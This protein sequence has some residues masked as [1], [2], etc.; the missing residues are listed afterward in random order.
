MPRHSLRS[1][2]QKHFTGRREERQFLSSLSFL[3]TF[4]TTR[5]VTHAIRDDIGPFHNVTPRGLH[6]HHLVWGIFGLLG[7]GYAWLNQVGTGL[8]QSSVRTS[9]FTSL[10][11]GAGAALTLDEFALWLHLEDD[12][13]SKEGRDSIDAVVVFISLLSVGFWGRWFFRDV[14]RE[15]FRLDGHEPE[16]ESTSHDSPADARE[17]PL[18]SDSTA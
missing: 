10:A 6:I 11:Y 5:T 8:E 15:L 16:D 12:Y 18:G 3:V 9:R 14:A 7:V 13:W 4:A 1:I 2:Y 17:E